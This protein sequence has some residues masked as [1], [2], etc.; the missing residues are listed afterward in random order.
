[1]TDKPLK[2]KRLRRLNQDSSKKQR[3]RQTNQVKKTQSKKRRDQVQKEEAKINED[4]LST[5][6][7]LDEGEPKT[8]GPKLGEEGILKGRGRNYGRKD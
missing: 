3:G 5:R 6:P 8:R 4:R 2:T 1:M 7:K